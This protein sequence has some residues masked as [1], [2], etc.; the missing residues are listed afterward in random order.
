MYY[1]TDKKTYH[2][3]ILY[4]IRRIRKR[5]FI[6]NTEDFITLHNNKHLCQHLVDICKAMTRS[7]ELQADL[8]F[9]AWIKI[10]DLLLGKTL[11]F[12]VG[13]G[14]NAMKD[15]Y[16]ER[17]YHKKYIG[18]ASYQRVRRYAKKNIK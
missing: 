18:S 16:Q 12:Y 7:P 2:M 8:L 9:E 10:G 5:Y 14:V 13:H 15:Y 17:R 1:L 4:D 3:D 11:K 6:L